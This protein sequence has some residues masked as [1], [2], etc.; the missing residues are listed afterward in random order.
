M[1]QYC[2]PRQRPNSSPSC[3]NSPTP[4]NA[5]TAPRSNTTTTPSPTRSVT[6]APSIRRSDQ[7]HSDTSRRASAAIRAHPKMTRFYNP[8]KQ[9]SSARMGRS[10]TPTSDGGRAYILGPASGLVMA[11]YEWSAEGSPGSIRARRT[12]CLQRERVL[13]M[14]QQPSLHRRGHDH[15]VRPTSQSSGRISRTS[16]AF[17]L[18]KMDQN[19]A[20]SASNAL[21]VEC[22]VIPRSRWTLPRRVSGCRSRPPSSF[23]APPRRAGSE[24]RSQAA[25]HAAA[26]CTSS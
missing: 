1:F 19:L 11:H 16:M 23:P 2:R 22:C 9:R 10:P 21:I 26:K 15:G 12:A 4:S 7:R 5:T 14:R 20:A 17:P 24:R 25:R 13:R 6:T 3:T 8:A 18:A